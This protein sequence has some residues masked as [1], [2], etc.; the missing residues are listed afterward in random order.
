MKIARVEAIHLRIP[1]VQEIADGTQ[2]VLV[3]RIQTDSG[4][5]GIGEVTSQSYVCKAIFEAPPSAARRHGLAHLLLGQDP[6]DVEG[7]WQHMD[8]SVDF[9]LRTDP[10]IVILQFNL[11]FHATFNSK[12]FFDC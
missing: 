11:P 1:E 9:P 6:L 7:L 2:D 4:L 3:I 12:I 10:E 8:L 5:E